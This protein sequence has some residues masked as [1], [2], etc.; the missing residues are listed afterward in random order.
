[1][2]P[3]NPVTATMGPSAGSSKGCSTSN[4]GLHPPVFTEGN[5]AAKRVRPGFTRASAL[6][7]AAPTGALHNVHARWQFSEDGSQWVVRVLATA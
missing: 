5:G 7:G 1:M 3:P 2:E 6:S 4:T